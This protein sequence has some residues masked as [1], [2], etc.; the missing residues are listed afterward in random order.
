MPVKV[1]TATDR[2]GWVR[3]AE[4]W[5][6]VA[7]KLNRPED[8]RVDENFYVNARDILKPVADSTTARKAQ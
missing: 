5:K 7:V 4:R 6:S 3:P 8:F 1:T 2:L